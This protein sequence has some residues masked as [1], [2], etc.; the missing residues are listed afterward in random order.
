MVNEAELVKRYNDFKHTHRDSTWR[1]MSHHI[2]LQVLELQM[3]IEEL[4]PIQAKEAET[5]PVQTMVSEPKKSWFKRST[6]K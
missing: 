4:S 6:K 5:N 2:M 3:K 1:D